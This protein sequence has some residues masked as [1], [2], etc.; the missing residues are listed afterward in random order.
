MARGLVNVPVELHS[1]RGKDSSR[2]TEPDMTMLDERNLA[3]VGYKLKQSLEKK[4]AKRA[5]ARK[6]RA[7]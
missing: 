4:P 5:S 3:P 1:A 7:A 2:S 6:R